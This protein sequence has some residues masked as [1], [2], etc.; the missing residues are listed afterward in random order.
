[1]ASCSTSQSRSRTV[2][3]DRQSPVRAGLGDLF[4]G[5]QEVGQPLLSVEPAHRQ[6]QEGVIGDAEARAR[7]GSAASNGAGSIPLGMTV[8][9]SGS[10]PPTSRLNRATP[11]E[12][13]TDPRGQPAGQAIERQVPAASRAR[14]RA[15]RRRPRAFPPKARPAA[16][17][18]WRGT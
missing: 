18:G 6:R 9:R 8:S 5:R 12:T 13:Q 11:A 3:D 7:H 15:G 14:R 1:M 16:P 4:G 10:R 2:A 17:P